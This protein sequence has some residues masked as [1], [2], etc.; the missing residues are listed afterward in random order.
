MVDGRGGYRDDCAWWAFRKVS[1]LCGLRYQEMIKDVEAAWGEIEEKAFAGQKDFE[2][3]VVATLKSNPA[4]A[5]EM[6]T[7]YSVDMANDAV[8]RYRKLEEELWSKHTRYF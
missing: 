4:K 6:L 3:Q 5:A 2:S 1:Q 7:K 8:E